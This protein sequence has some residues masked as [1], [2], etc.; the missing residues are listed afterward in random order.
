MSKASRIGII[1]ALPIEA[2]CFIKKKLWVGQTLSLKNNILLHIGGMGSVCAQAAAHLLISR[3]VDALVSWGVAGGLAPNIRSGQLV[4]PNKIIDQKNNVF[5]VNSAWRDQLQQQLEKHLPVMDGVLLQA[6]QMI[7]TVADK[8]QLFQ[9]SQAVAVDMESA[10]IAA[11]AEQA[12]LPFIAVRSVTDAA[13]CSLP[14]WMQQSL[15]LSGEVKIGALI[16]KLYYHPPR[17]IA[18]MQMSRDFSAATSTLQ[19]VASLCAFEEEEAE[20]DILALR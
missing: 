7:T 2:R 12:K 16:S 20:D 10:A 11:V 14:L 9:Q 4:L 15:A 19:K 17:L 18:L 5:P 13:D 6:E 3:G 1:T 8:Q